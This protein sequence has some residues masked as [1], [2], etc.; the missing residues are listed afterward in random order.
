MRNKTKFTRL[1][2]EDGR[3]VP[4]TTGIDPTNIKVSFPYRGL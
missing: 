2:F 1:P 3:L 4:W